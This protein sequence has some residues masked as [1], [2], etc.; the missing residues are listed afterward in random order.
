MYPYGQVPQTFLNP[1]Q[2][3]QAQ[4]RQIEQL[5]EQ[6]QQMQSDLE[7]LRL[8][9][10]EIHYNFDQLKIERLDGTLNIGWGAK[11]QDD[12]LD[13]LS[14]N[15]ESLE[16]TAPRDPAMQMMQS[17]RND[18]MHYMNGRALD[19]MKQL[20]ERCEYPLDEPYRKFI[21]R[22]L[23]KQVD[24][25]IRH[26]YSQIKHQ[27]NDR[28][29]EELAKQIAEKVRNDVYRGMEQFLGQLKQGRDAQ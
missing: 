18:V 24:P 27:L 4:Q 10:R 19:D 7:E 11:G 25:R 22:D 8:E 29:R 12:G 26:Y 21:L 20:E 28:N 3:M 2:H 1:Q 13:D 15:G 6:L 14:V 23:Q 9:P 5:Q 16:T 17:A